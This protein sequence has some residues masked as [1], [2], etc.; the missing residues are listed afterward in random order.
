M[1]TNR[2][3]GNKRPQ[4]NLIIIVSQGGQT[5]PKYFNHFKKNDGNSVLK[6]ELAK[7]LDPISVVRR[8]KYLKEEQYVLGRNDKIYC[9]YD[10]D[11]SPEEQLNEAQKL[12]N[13]NNV[14]ACVSNP[15]FEIWYL[16]HYRYSTAAFNSYEDVKRELLGYISDYDKNKDVFIRLQLHQ[17]KAISHAKNLE[18]HHSRG[19]IASIRGRNPSTQIHDL[20]GFLNKISQAR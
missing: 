13:K 19:E 17:E 6:V 8:A 20:V 16:L 18:Q 3:G 4:K 7:G 10:V 1:G 5:E 9:V 2:Q 11:N 15:C 12:A 14:K